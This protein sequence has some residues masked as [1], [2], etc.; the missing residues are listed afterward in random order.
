MYV[1]VLCD[2]L[3][4]LKIIC[5]GSSTILYKNYIIILF[6]ITLL[7]ISLL[8][9]IGALNLFFK[10]LGEHVVGRESDFIVTVDAP[11]IDIACGYAPPGT[12]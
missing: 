11:S 5:V 10:Y 12:E 9:K 1:F 6:E 8:I 4:V 2:Y 3:F 7:G